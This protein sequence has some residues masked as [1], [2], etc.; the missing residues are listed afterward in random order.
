MMCACAP[1]LKPLFK[2]FST[3]FSSRVSNG[4]T[5]SVPLASKGGGDR[6]GGASAGQPTN[7]IALNSSIAR[8]RARFEN[9]TPSPK[10]DSPESRVIS[11]TGG[12]PYY[13]P[14][15]EP[16]SNGRR[17]SNGYSGPTSLPSTAT[18]FRQS[19]VPNFQLDGSFGFKKMQ[20][21]PEFH[22]GSMGGETY[23]GGDNRGHRPSKLAGEYT[24]TCSSTHSLAK[25]KEGPDQDYF[26]FVHRPS[27]WRRQ[28]VISRQTKSQSTSSTPDTPSELEVK[29]E[30]E[31]RV[32]YEL[33]T[34]EEQ[35]RWERKRSVLDAVDSLW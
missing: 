14:P 15:L 19:S 5:G 29:I 8:N 32:D 21:T 28:S 13:T 9:V 4:N 23:R 31:V 18:R 27:I 25:S 17:S 7:G 34:E 16:R 24:V 6:G 26:G 3:P 22:N 35:E 2:T 33:M 10:R 30:H 20:S 11:I 1:A 12:T